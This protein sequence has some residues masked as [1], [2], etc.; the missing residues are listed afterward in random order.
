MY[1]NLIAKLNT[2]QYSIKC[3]MGRGMAPTAPP[4]KAAPRA[5][6][7]YTLVGGT[8]SGDHAD[9]TFISKHWLYVPPLMML[10]FS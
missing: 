7:M 8:G 10:L 9:Q 2:L 3:L 4:K 1:L 5:H 6:I